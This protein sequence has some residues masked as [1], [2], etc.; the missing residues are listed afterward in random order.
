MGIIIA[1]TLEDVLNVAR[2]LGRYEQLGKYFGIKALFEY[3]EELSD[4]IGEPWEL[5]VVSWCCEWTTYAATIAEFFENYGWKTPKGLSDQ[6]LIQ[7]LREHTEVIE[8]HDG[9]HVRDF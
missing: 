7:Y 1:A 5:D 9:V 3:Q 2:K 8:F 4:D 6:K